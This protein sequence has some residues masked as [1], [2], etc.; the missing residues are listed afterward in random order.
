MHLGFTEAQQKVY[1]S[2]LYDGEAGARMI[3][4]RTGITRTSVY[5]QIETLK[6]RGLV[7]DYTT[8]GAT[9]FLVKD[10][11]Q[12][13][14]LLKE[15]IDVTQGHIAYA[16]D[17]LPTLQK[18]VSSDQPRIVFFEGVEGIKQMMK[19]ML[20]HDGIMLQ[21]YWSYSETLKVFGEDFLLWFNSRRIKNEIAVQ[22]IW[23]V[24]MKKKKDHIFADRD[25]LVERRYVT[26]ADVPAM[27]YIIYEDKVL[28]L[29]SAREAFG[30]VVT[31]R[32]HATLQRMQFQAL[33]K[34]S[35]V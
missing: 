13:V 23:P 1:L 11:E 18:R 30:Y 14:R 31:S 2:L 10:P 9:T 3:S 22:A 16:Q 15:D 29:S 17:I 20:W 28:F 33:W 4:S 34:A 25:R 7:A 35:K 24:G 26:C 8:E 32:E 27:S 21:I 12:I 19:D 5:D 6:D